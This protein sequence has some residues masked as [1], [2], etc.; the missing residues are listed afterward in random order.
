M[1]IK[2][3]L[4]IFLLLCSSNVSLSSTRTLP[5]VLSMRPFM[6]QAGAPVFST[7]PA[8][9]DLGPSAVGVS[10]PVFGA[11][12]PFAI[13]LQISNTGTAS[14]TASFSFSSPE[15]AFDSATHLANPVTVASASSVTGGLVFTPSAA[16]SRTGQFISSDNAAGSPHT[17]ALSGTGIT[18]TNNDF[19][20]I[21][22]PSQASPVILRAGQ[23]TSFKLWILAGPGLNASASVVGSATCTGGPNG[24]S[25]SITPQTFSGGFNQTSTRQMVT[26]TVNVPAGSASLHRKVPVFWAV[27]LLPLIGIVFW[28]RA[29]VPHL[30]L[31]ALLA[32]AFFIVSCGGG[33]GSGTANP[34]IVTVSA[35]GLGTTHTMTVP[36]S[37]Q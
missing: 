23:T 2:L 28:R 13:P 14:L 29:W 21:V 10:T 27:V 3:L 4:P 5:V 30:S 20:I 37:V 1:R 9:V 7:T 34:L 8:S 11:P 22:D 16:G 33:G 6:M 24:S 19:G 35:V 17:V 18:V 26:V 25:C 15:F 32:L 36:T 12:P 31:V